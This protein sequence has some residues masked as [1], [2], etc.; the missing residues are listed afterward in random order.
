MSW[1]TAMLACQ[2]VTMVLSNFEDRRKDKMRSSLEDRFWQ[3]AFFFLFSCQRGQNPHNG[4]GA[5]RSLRSTCPFELIWLDPLV[6]HGNIDNLGC[7]G[8]FCRNRRLSC[9]HCTHANASQNKSTQHTSE[10]GRY[11]CS[12][13]LSP[14]G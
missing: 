1:G 13:V 10:L 14:R 8:S 9:R 12:R 7:D 5:S 2:N 4:D 11:L 6:Q 3:K